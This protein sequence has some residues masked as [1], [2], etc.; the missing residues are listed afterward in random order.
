MQRQ[1]DSDA[2]SDSEDEAEA[3][4]DSQADEA[5]PDADAGA[6]SS[7][8]TDVDEADSNSRSEDAATDAGGD[9]DS[10][11]DAHPMQPAGRSSLFSKI[12]SLF[13]VRGQPASVQMCQ[14]EGGLVWVLCIQTLSLIPLK[15][16]HRRVC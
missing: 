10:G 16:C 13:M 1:A 5:A 11:T 3:E 2:A 15:D 12:A 9:A 4:D 14:G 6:E 8:A 7:D